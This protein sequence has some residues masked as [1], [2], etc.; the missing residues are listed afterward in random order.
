MVIGDIIKR[1]AKRYPDKVA[2]SFGNSK[3][4]FEEFNGRVNRVVN[5]L[6]ALGLNKGDMVAVLLDNCPQFVELYCASAKGGLALLPLNCR[7]GGQDLA[8]LVNDAGANTLVFGDNYLSV[9]DSMRSDLKTV[10]NFIVVGT[11]SGLRSYDELFSQYPSDEPVIEIREEDLAYLLYTSDTTGLPK[12]VMHTHKSIM[13]CMLNYMIMAGTRCNDVDLAATPLFWI[14]GLVCHILLNFYMG[15]SIVFL[16]DFT[17]ELALEA[18]EREGVTTTFLLP[19]QIAS[20]LD[21]PNLDKYDTH[22]LRHIWYGGVPLSQAVLRRAVATFGNIFHQGY[23]LVEETPIAV[24]PAADTALDG[25]PQ[26]VKRLASCGREAIN[27][28]VRVIDD[29]GNDVAPGE[30]GELIARGDN[31]MK[32]Y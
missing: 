12:G 23:G 6:T 1:S 26:E 27:V 7:L 29:Y 3:Y 4:T 10:N 16:Q 18:I 20:L 2:F 31:M 30:I 9:I 15:A 22:S 32:G 13:G 28:D 21:H 25:S 14:P 8:Y 24:L 11:G 5:G 17:P 19:P